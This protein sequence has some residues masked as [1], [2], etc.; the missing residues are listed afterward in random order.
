[1]QKFR[2]CF[3]CLR[4]SHMLTECKGRTCSVPNCGRQQ[5]RLL[6]SNLSKNDAT[7]NVSD[8]TTAVATNITHGGPPVVRIK[9]TNRVL[10]LNV[11]EMFDSGSLI[12]F[13]GKS[14]MSDRQLQGRKASLSLAGIHGSEDVKTE[15]VPIAVS[16]DE[17]SRLFTTVP[18]YLQEKLKLDD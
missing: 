5:N 2:L 13:V 18:F 14:V 8:A 15:K 12:S 7:K 1:M 4:P 9:L 16:T 11:L 10:S 3:N 6:H 17:K